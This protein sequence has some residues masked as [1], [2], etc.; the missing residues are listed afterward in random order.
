[1]NVASVTPAPGDVSATLALQSTPIQPPDRLTELLSAPS[2]TY[3]LPTLGGSESSLSASVIG[4]RNAVPPAAP[5]EVEPPNRAKAR[6]VCPQCGGADVKTLGGG[7]K[8]KYRYSCLSCPFSWQQVPP[9]KLGSSGLDEPLRL[10]LAVRKRTIHVQYKCARCGLPKK[11]HVCTG[12]GGR[13]VVLPQAQVRHHGLS[14]AHSL[15]YPPPACSLRRRRCFRS[16]SV[17]AKLLRLTRFVLTTAAQ[18]RLPRA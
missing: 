3:A 12:T 16:R 5:L 6:P 10:G 7:T 15:A 9:H 18:P 1:M 4:Q 11:G 8:G 14:L 17:L 13:S 2:A